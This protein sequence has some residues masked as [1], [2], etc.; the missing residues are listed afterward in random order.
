MAAQTRDNALA[1]Q[2]FDGM[3]MP[4]SRWTPGSRVG[5]LFANRR[6]PSLFLCSKLELIK[7]AIRERAYHM[8]MEA[9]R[10]EVNAAGFGLPPNAR[11]WSYPWEA[12]PE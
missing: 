7:Q 3:P 6:G 5:R 1:T 2:E 8:W 4:G 11:S 12:S 9:G 10:P